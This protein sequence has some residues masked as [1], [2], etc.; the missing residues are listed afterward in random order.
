MPVSLGMKI[1]SLSNVA[2]V[3]TGTAVFGTVQKFRQHRSN[4]WKSQERIL[5][6]AFTF[7]G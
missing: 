6:E 3:W 2:A 5:S 1:Y 7:P 4:H